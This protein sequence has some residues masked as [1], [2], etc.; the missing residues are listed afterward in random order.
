MKTTEN[1]PVAGSG[2]PPAGA[3]VV[4]VRSLLVG[5]ANQQDAWIRQLVSEIIIAG[6]ALSLSRSIGTTTEYRVSLAVCGVVYSSESYIRKQ[7]TPLY[8]HLIQ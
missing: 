2:M 5:W 8:Y 3:P 1:A 4:T 6:K 7:N